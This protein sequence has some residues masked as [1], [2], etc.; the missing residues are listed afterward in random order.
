LLGLALLLAF[1]M[2][3]IIPVGIGAVAVG[4]LE[5]LRG[6][7]A[8]RRSFKVAGGVIL[9]AAGLYMLNAVFFWIPGL[10]A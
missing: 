1:A 9:I 2:G 3:R 6:V 7:A 8:Y 5:N 4:W 10:A